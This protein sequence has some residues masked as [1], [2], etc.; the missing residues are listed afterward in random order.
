MDW[1]TIWMQQFLIKYLKLARLLSMGM[2]LKQLHPLVMIL[3]MFTHSYTFHAIQ[4][5]LTLGL[6]LGSLEKLSPS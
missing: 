3:I 1:C 4:M 2:I 6:F 5:M